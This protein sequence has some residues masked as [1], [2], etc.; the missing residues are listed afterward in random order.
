[1]DFSSKINCFRHMN[2]NAALKKCD[3][4]SREAER[5]WCLQGLCLIAHTYWEERKDTTNAMQT[6]ISQEIW[7]VSVPSRLENLMKLNNSMD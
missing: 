2:I 6:L 1:M 3:E 5:M 7:K 4:I